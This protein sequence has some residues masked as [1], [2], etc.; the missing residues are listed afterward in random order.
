MPKK[1]S[2]ETLPKPNSKEETLISLP[3]RRY[4][5]IRFLRRNEVMIQIGINP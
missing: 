1:Y 2:F 3:V 5:V 4:A